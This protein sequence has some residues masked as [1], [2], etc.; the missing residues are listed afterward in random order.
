MVSKTSEKGPTTAVRWS[1][2]DDATLVE[3]FQVEKAKA[4]WGDNGPKPIV[5]TEAVKTLVGSEQTSG[6]GPKTLHA[7]KNRWQKVC[8]DFA[9]GSRSE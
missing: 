9:L 3:T 5:Y 8:M 1:S 7:V 4:N 6:G 2:A